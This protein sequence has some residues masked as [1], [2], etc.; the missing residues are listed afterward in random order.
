LNMKGKTWVIDNSNKFY[1]HHL[2]NC[3]YNLIPI[4]ITWKVRDHETVYQL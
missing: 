2:T 3:A 4:N 1:W